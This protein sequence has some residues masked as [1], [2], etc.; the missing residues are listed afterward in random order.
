[1]NY[2]TAIRNPKWPRS[3]YRPD[4]K[5]LG[6]QFKHQE[7]SFHVGLVECSEWRCGRTSLLTELL[8]DAEQQVV[9]DRIARKTRRRARRRISRR[10]PRKMW[11]RSISRKSTR[12]R[13]SSPPKLFNEPVTYDTKTVLFLG[14]TMAPSS[15]TVALS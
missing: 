2:A 14:K 8:H 13:R 9:K 3:P 10:M 5:A 7:G 6:L 12:T 1:M 11:K 4:S 15:L